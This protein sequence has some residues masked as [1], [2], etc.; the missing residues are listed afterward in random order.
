MTPA[1]ALDLHS[2]CILQSSVVHLLEL[3]LKKLHTSVCTLHVKSFF[4]FFCDGWKIMDV[5][6]GSSPVSSL[7]KFLVI[8]TSKFMLCVPHLISRL[9]NC[10]TCI[11]FLKE[12]C[13]RSPNS[14]DGNPNSHPWGLELMLWCCTS[15][16][17]IKWARLTSCGHA[18]LV[19]VTSLL[20]LDT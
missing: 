14:I 4:G 5:I 1:A 6:S 7:Y 11:L 12:N 17:P 19:V 15:T 13:R 10:W 16:P 9:S 8:L 20:G 3:I 18:A 2:W